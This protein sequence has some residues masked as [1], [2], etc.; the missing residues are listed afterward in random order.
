M[1]LAET[2]VLQRK[3]AGASGLEAM[4]YGIRSLEVQAV[5]SVVARLRSY[6]RGNRTGN[7]IK[8][9]CNEALSLVEISIR[10]GLLAHSSWTSV[11]TPVGGS[12]FFNERNF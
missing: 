7:N 12:L 2:L 6:S 3:I 4:P 8:Q 10:G 1:M 11:R 5:I 9:V